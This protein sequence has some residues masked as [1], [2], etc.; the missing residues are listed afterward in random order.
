MAEAM[1]TTTD[2]SASCEKPIIGMR[3]TSAVLSSAPGA[4]PAATSALG[5]VRCAG[6]KAF[7]SSTE[8]LPV[9]I[10]PIVCQSSMMVRSRA[11]TRK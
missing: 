11:G 7:L 4:A 2:A 10:I 9:P 1:P 5:S 6:T 8:Q 3:K